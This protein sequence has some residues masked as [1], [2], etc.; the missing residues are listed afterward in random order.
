MNLMQATMVRAFGKGECDIRRV[1]FPTALYL[2]IPKVALPVW[3]ITE[4][5]WQWGETV[6]LYIPICSYEPSIAKPDAVLPSEQGVLIKKRC[7]EGAQ[8]R[9]HRTA[10]LYV[11]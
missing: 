6:A 7:I 10:A 8:T 2:K 9:M 11:V 3:Y 4:N 5:F 1:A